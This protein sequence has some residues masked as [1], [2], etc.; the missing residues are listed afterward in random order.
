MLG[1]AQ[2]EDVGAVGVKLYYP[3]ETIQHAGIAVGIQTV[4]SHLFRDIPKD[5]HGYFARE[6]TIQ[7][8]SAVTAAC[9]MTKRDIYE[10]VGYMD[11]KFAVAFNDIDFCLKIRE[12]NKLIV[13]NPFVELIHYESKTRG[14]DNTPEKK[15]RFE[16]EIK[17]FLNKWNKFLEKGDPYFNI[18]FDRFSNKCDINLNKINS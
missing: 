8:M 11:E 4:A 16:G 17:R 14:D 1:F 5:Q 12:L 13:Y 9:I 6:S 10:K 3:D 2:R 7:D 18:N 15:K